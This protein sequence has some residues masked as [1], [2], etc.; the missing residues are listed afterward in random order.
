MSHFSYISRSLEIQGQK[1]DIVFKLAARKIGHTDW[2]AIIQKA[3]ES[4]IRL[5]MSFT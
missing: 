4:N 1:L 3:E 2:S 5:Q